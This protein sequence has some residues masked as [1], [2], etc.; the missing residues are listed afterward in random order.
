M[1]IPV[2]GLG[3]GGHAK[4]VIEIL[5]LDSRYR[6]IGLLDPNPEFA[7]TNVLGVPII[8]HD[9]CLP[10]LKKQGVDHFFVGLGSVGYMVPRKRLYELGRS[11]NMTPVDAIHP[12]SIVSSSA[13]IGPGVTIGANSI[14]NACAQLGE[15]VIVNTGAIVEHDCLIGNHVHVATGAILTSTVVVGDATHIGAGAIIRQCIRIGENVIV[16]AGA[17]VVKDV[18]SGT[19]V[20]GVPA[21]ELRILGE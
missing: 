21:H 3:A 17:V 9:D 13:L 12:R 2:V 19:V 7:N 15:N 6:L 20:V 18:S 4:V 5:R 14:I 16:G 1:T 11:M 10:Y 8:G